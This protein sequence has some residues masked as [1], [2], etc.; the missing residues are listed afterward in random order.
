MG[1]E[2]RVLSS[3]IARNRLA[4]PLPGNKTHPRSAVVP[5]VNHLSGL[6]ARPAPWPSA[7]GLALIPD[8]IAPGLPCSD[9]P[10]P[11]STIVFVSVRVC[12]GCG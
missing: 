9:L 7:G 8:M 6:C 11:Y 12:G 5:A 2:S 10:C 1:R 4:L 3:G